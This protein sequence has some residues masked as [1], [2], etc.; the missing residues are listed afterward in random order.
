MSTAL[1]RLLIRVAICINQQ[2]EFCLNAAD[3]YNCARGLWRV[4]RKR[5]E[6]ANYA[7]AVYQGVI[8]EVYEIERWVPVT[9]NRSDF[10]LERLR[11]QG[12]TISPLE[13]EGGVGILVCC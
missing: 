5:A 9:K 2:H 10:W 12:R 6:K 8:K 1:L 3:F 7:F 11:S 13:H 4:N